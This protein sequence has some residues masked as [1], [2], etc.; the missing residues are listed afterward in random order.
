MR[1]DDLYPDQQKVFMET[2][3][4]FRA[5]RSVLIQAATG[6][7]KTAIA[8]ATAKSATTRGNSVMMMVHRREL[9]KQASGAFEKAGIPH[10]LIAAGVTGNRH[11]TA[12]VA[13]VGTLAN[14]L[15]RYPAP[16]LLI[17][18]EA[19]HSGAKSWSDIIDYYAERGTRIL[20]LSATPERLDG[21]GLGRW[22]K[23]MVC[24]PSVRWLMDHGR[25]SDY[26]LFA[27]SPGQLPDLSGI[28]KTGGDLNRGQTAEVMSGTKVVGNAVAE[29]S[30][31]AHG[32][33]AVVFCVSIKHSLGVVEK[34][35]AAGYRAVHID[36]E[37]GDR[38]EILRDFERGQIDVLCSVDL[39][40][41]GF[42]VP[43]IECAI[44]LRPT[45]SLSLWI[46]QVG[47]ALRVAPGKTHAIILDHAGNSLPKEAG[48]RG[49]GLPDQDRV[50]TLEGRIKKSR[51]AGSGEEA[52]PTRQCPVC[53]RVHPPAPTCPKCGHEYPT[54]GRTVEELAGILTKV[55][56]KDFVAAAAKSDRIE[57][58]QA[59]TLEDLIRI[60]KMRGHKNPGF[61]AR[62]IMESRAAKTQ[63]RRA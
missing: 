61:W 59:Q 38:D 52:V 26:E 7:G 17:V 23:Q 51:G 12:Q 39:I 15:D 34:F 27:P 25:L 8:S 44:S 58:G 55:E 13:L 62:K 57:Q 9:L 2:R 3:D 22:F 54:M 50:W 63:R 36:G 49:H 21:T 6:F 60:G 43:G 46:Q 30:K 4:A 35:R 32:K 42:D 11:S 56:R 29:Y 20:G 24:G 45:A 53:Y 40:S 1:Y 31:I 19:H 16:K 18:D 14:R 5:S 48:G 10:G 28:R 47:R 33:R 41:E 37:S